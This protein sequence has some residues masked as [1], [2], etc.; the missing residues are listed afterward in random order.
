MLPEAYVR[1]NNSATSGFGKGWGVFERCEGLEVSMHIWT[2][3]SLLCAGV[4]LPAS[5]AILWD[6]FKTHWRC[7]SFTPND[8][9]IANLSIMDF[10]FLASIPFGQLNMY[11]WKC[12]LLGAV[13]DAVYSLNTCGRPLLMAC[14]CLDCYLAVVHPI[15][16]RKRTSLV[17]RLVMA[18]FV[19][20]LTVA[21]G[22]VYFLDDMLFFTMFPIVTFIIAIVIIIF[23]DCFIVLT[24]MKSG[25]GGRSIHPQKQRALQ[26][27]I[28]S[29][30]M[31]V[32][33][34]LPPVFLFTI[35][36]HLIS[37]VLVFIC[38]IGFSL[39]ITS[40]FGSAVMPLLYLYTV[41][42]LDFLW[43]RCCRI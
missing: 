29:L 40:T 32:I 28:Y 34:Y 39:T 1:L 31:A 11:I 23:C 20:I 7:A 22:I 17:P 9:F 10:V 19:W 14:I 33:S 43:V 42:K 35:G 16:Y 15:I 18:S 37:S 27:L 21:S 6:M 24:L 26:T 8:F 38:T 13:W 4:G 12:E 36:R 25:P 2:F 30:A 41:G 3:S 5:I